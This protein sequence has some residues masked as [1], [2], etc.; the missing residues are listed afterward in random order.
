MLAV[1]TG[2]IGCADE[3]SGSTSEAPPFVFRS[4]KLNQKKPDGL[5]DWS[6]NSPE[7][8]YELSRQLV[9]ARDPIALLY[10][11][12]KPSFRV[13]SDLAL[14]VNDGEQ[15]LLE[16][17]VRLQQLNGA[18]L[19]I[20]GDRLRWQP[21]QGLLLIEQRPRATDGTS[22]IGAS[23]AQLQQRTN[24]LTL[25]GVV[26]LERWN[27]DADASNPDTT[28]RTGPAQWNLDTGLLNAQGPVLGQRRDEEG[29]VLEQLQGQ[30][31]RGNTI[32]GDITVQAPVNVQIPR[33]K[34][35][36]RAQDTTWNFREQ[37]IRSEQ[38]FE[39]DL[40]EAQIAG[41]RFRA[42]LNDTTVD[43]ISDC[44]IEQPGEKLTADRCL[45]NWQSEEVLA[46]GN[47][48]LLREA[49]DQIT[50][51]SRLEGRV[52]EEG[53]ITF[54]APGGK[55][56]SQVRFRSDEQDPSSG[57]RNQSAPVEF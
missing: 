33:E 38:P 32:Q 55:V 30:N 26:E 6:L 39:A 27:E 53:L 35:V 13:Q 50:R 3:G 56:E 40:D 17:D 20:Q 24:D 36:L 12:G 34:G 7:A 51:A 10:K 2:L 29:T 42:D 49:N 19:L 23:E 25:N 28:L 48:Q 14:V 9:R 47:V 15:I 1:I 41:G 16:G 46:E 54:T 21:E 52:G 57:R 22:R 44:R 37:T 31:L 43:V 18:K 5:M 45:W 8:R 4:L 11:D